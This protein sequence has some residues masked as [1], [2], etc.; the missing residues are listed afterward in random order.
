MAVEGVPTPPLPF[1]GVA[2]CRIVDT[3][4]NGAPIQGGIYTD[5]QARNY[6][7]PGICGIPAQ[8][9]AV[10]LNITVTGAP[11]APPG[12]FLL[13]WPQGGA[14]PPVSILNY[15]AGQ[16]LA[17]AAIVPLGTAG[18]I[19]VNVSHSVHVIIDTNGYFAPQIVVNTVN[20]L[21]GA[22]TLAPGSNITITPSGQTLTIASSAAPAGWSLTGN[23]GTTPGTNFLGTTDN[24]ALEL[25]VSNSRA[26][27]LE[28]AST[29]NVIGGHSTNSVTSGGFGATIAGGGGSGFNNRV[30]D[31]YGTI[32][33]G[34]GNQA[35][36]NAG[37]IFD[38]TYATVGGG[39]NNM[40][41]GDAA[42]IGGG[43]SNIA[44]G[45]RGTVG[46]GSGNTAS[47]TDA[48][49]GAGNSNI[50]SGN[51]GTVGGGQSNVA[52]GYIATIGGGVANTA[53]GDYG[54]IPG[55][56]FNT[57]L[58]SFSFAAGRRAKANHQ[59]AF[60]WGDSSEA[61]VASTAVNQFIVRASGGIWLGTTSAPSITIANDFLNTSTGAHLTIGGA[62]TNSSDF[63]RK[64]NFE[65]VDRHDLLERLATL[66]I[67]RWS[68]KAEDCSVHHMGPTGQDFAAA[69][70]LGTDDT[71]IAT[72]DADGVAF[73]A[74]QA[75][76]E[77]VKEKDVELEALKARLSKLESSALK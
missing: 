75:L 8:A 28:P 22:V 13:A 50:A 62:W 56:F 3:R 7:L 25:K 19:T 77:I 4:G 42:S 27:R 36:N 18:G 37:T 73:A 57:A 70:G 9:E 21:S 76:Y 65:E 48:T 63:G 64:E 58:G 69:F 11:S 39:Y 23:A 72:V 40:A 6:A 67:T 43:D 53:S 20:G 12:A 60:V 35:G 17:N 16:T 34:G 32:G 29:P 52:G 26:F 68:Y 31:N 51:S 30:T 74:I 49:V 15:Q 38:K 59:G 41:S 54:T 14:V 1:V 55:G 47:G 46:G 45:T 71:S 2:P 44:S 66:P 24:Q 5:G 10:S 33:G 61:D